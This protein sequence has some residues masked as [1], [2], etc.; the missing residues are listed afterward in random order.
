M[1]AIKHLFSGNKNELQTV[2]AENDKLSC[3]LLALEIQIQEMK[4]V[5]SS[6][7]ERISKHDADITA[8]K[9]QNKDLKRKNE[10]LEEENVKKSSRTLI[11]CEQLKKSCDK[12]SVTREQT[13]L[14][15]LDEAKIRAE[16]TTASLDKYNDYLFF[17]TYSLYISLELNETVGVKEDISVETNKAEI[18][19]I[20]IQSSPYA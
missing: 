1:I 17:C 14:L 2:K 12:I 9:Q 11:L 18:S 10:Q 3:K 13:R 20:T 7:T 4:S 5:I 19:G 6:N 8:R 15:D 16:Q